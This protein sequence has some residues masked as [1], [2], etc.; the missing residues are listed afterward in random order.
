MYPTDWLL[1]PGEV[2]QG[3]T[4]SV[5]AYVPSV[6]LPLSSEVK[7]KLAVGRTQK[8][9]EEV[10]PGEFHCDSTWV[11]SFQGAPVPVHFCVFPWFG[12]S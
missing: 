4:A 3:V 10:L 2:E 8:P 7:P 1:L 11:L 6:D 9:T 12:I 5:P